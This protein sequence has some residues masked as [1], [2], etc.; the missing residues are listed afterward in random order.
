VRDG[1]APL[2][3]LISGPANWALFFAAAY[4]CHAYACARPT[5]LPVTEIILGLAGAAILVSLWL[6]RRVPV[7]ISGMRSAGRV[8]HL[9]SLI[10]IL[11][12]ATAVLSIPA[13]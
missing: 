7:R 6:L 5:D 4:A 3:L 11:W 1:L 2:L 9:L 13:C 10:G 8:L 12:T